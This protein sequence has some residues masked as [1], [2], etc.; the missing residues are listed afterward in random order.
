MLEHRFF[1][2]RKSGKVSIGLDVVFHVVKELTEDVPRHDVNPVGRE[3]LYIVQNVR[4][5]GERVGTER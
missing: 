5:V 3:A 1:A 2:G 4:D